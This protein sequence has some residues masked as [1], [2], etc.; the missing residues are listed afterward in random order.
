MTVSEVISKATTFWRPPDRDIRT[1]AEIEKLYGRIK[2]L[3]DRE[4]EGYSPYWATKEKQRRVEMLDHVET[5]LAWV[6]NLEDAGQFLFACC[7]VS[8]Y[9]DKPP[10][11]K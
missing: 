11:G 10:D 7:G 2:Q 3:H 4:L 6:L 9:L 8:E 1:E 5:V